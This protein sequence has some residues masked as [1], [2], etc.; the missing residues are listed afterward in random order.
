MFWSRLFSLRARG[1]NPG[2][3]ARAV[4][5]A[6]LTEALQNKTPVPRIPIRVVRENED[7]TYTGGFESLKQRPH[8]MSRAAQW[9]EAALNRVPDGPV[10]E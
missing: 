4:H 2:E 1:D 3:V 6:W 7:G 8:G 9:W 10:D 5:S